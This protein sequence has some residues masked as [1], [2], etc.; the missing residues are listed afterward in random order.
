LIIWV[1]NPLPAS[2]FTAEDTE[3]IRLFATAGFRT[4][5]RGIEPDDWTRL[6]DAD[7]LVTEVQ[8]TLGPG[9]QTPCN[10]GL[11]TRTTI[12]D[13]VAFEVASARLMDH[14]ILGAP[15]TITK[16]REVGLE[17]ALVAYCAPGTN[18]AA[19]RERLNQ[20][21]G[22][23]MLPDGSPA[24]FNPARWPLGRQVQLDELTRAIR[25]DPSVT[26]VVSDPRSDPRVVFETIHGDDDTTANIARGH[27]AIEA[28]QQARIGNDNFQPALGS[29]RIY[30][31]A[32]A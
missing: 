8:A 24:F 20:R 10:V 30:L 25:A 29:V 1:T 16:S 4:N 11:T 5:L 23:G 22:T 13:S 31:A 26:F 7:P 6:A 3:A 19:A 2:P 21:I 32:G 28:H 17:I 18:I 9:D 12:P 14:A 27:I 15:P